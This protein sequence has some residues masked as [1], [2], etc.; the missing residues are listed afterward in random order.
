MKF[1]ILFR[2]QDQSTKTVIILADT[3]EQAKKIFFAE[4]DGRIIT[5]DIIQ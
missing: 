4:Y 2:K 1:S 3:L 5:I